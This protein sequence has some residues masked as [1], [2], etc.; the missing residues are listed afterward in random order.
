MFGVFPVLFALFSAH[1]RRPFKTIFSLRGLS[2]VW[3]LRQRSPNHPVPA[4]FDKRHPQA[5]TM[6]F[7]AANPL[8]HRRRRLRAFLL[9]KFGFCF[10]RAFVSSR[11][12]PYLVVLL[13]PIWG[14]LQPILS[15]RLR[16]LL[17]LLRRRR[18]LMGV[19]SSVDSSH[20]LPPHAQLQ[21]DAHAQQP[22]PQ[23]TQSGQAQAGHDAAPVPVSGYPRRRRL[24]PDDPRL[25]NPPALG[26]DT[27]RDT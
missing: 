17:L 2:L 3:R 24:A 25:A 13:A 15:R 11:F 1:V 8:P 27:F 6:A 26:L 18:A 7:G 16:Q 19:A 23:P 22:Q 5:A 9:L 20:A 10:P 4:R 14:F 12:C 21:A